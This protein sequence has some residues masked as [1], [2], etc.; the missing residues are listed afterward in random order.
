MFVLNIRWVEPEFPSNQRREY[1][2]NPTQKT[3]PM[4][5]GKEVTV[6]YFGTL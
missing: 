5:V 1:G 4:S 2:M 6:S 3:P